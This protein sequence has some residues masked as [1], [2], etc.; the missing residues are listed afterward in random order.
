ALSDAQRQLLAR[1]IL[2]KQ[3]QQRR[4]ARAGQGP[5]GEPGQPS[6]T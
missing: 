4:L 2:Q 5:L 3:A 1:H 6:S